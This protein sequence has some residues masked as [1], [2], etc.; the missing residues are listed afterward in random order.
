MSHTFHIFLKRGIKWGSCVSLVLDFNK[1]YKDKNQHKLCSM[2]QVIFLSTNRASIERSDFKSPR[3]LFIDLGLVMDSK[4]SIYIFFKL[5]VLKVLHFSHLSHF[6][7]TTVI[8]YL[9][10][11]SVVF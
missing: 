7:V 5:G 11:Y 1:M 3:V 6:E 4:T 9:Y 10:T 8:M 2:I